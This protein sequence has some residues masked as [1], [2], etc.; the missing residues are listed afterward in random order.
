M[1]E[2]EGDHPLRSWADIA[3]ENGFDQSRIAWAE[4]RRPPDVEQ[5]R[6][7]IDGVLT[8]QDHGQ[9][10][11][12]ESSVGFARRLK[13]LMTVIE[14]LQQQVK[15]LNDVQK[16]PIAP[17]SVPIELAIEL[18]S[19]WSEAI[20]KLNWQELADAGFNSSKGEKGSLNKRNANTQELVKPHQKAADIIWND[21]PKLLKKVVADDVVKQMQKNRRDLVKKVRARLKPE[22]PYLDDADMRFD[23]SKWVYRKIQKT[24]K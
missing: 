15:E 1:A 13:G 24:K 5:I 17:I 3:T 8:E 23:Y 7:F 4:N 16:F 12:P 18:G 20:W 21:S 10:V 19:L 9:E 6:T 11:E 2:K 14:Q 22:T